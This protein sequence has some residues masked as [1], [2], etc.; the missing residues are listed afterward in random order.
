MARDMERLHATQIRR[1]GKGRHGD[2]G[3]LWLHVTDSGRYYFFRWGGSGRNYFSLGPAH[4]ISLSKAREKARACRELLLDGRDPKAEAI[5]Q[6]VI[7]KLKAQQPTFSQAADQYSQF[8]GP[9]AV[10]NCLVGNPARIFN[11]GSGRRRVARAGLHGAGPRRSAG[12][13]D[14]RRRRRP[15]PRRIEAEPGP[16]GRARG[17]E[18]RCSDAGAAWA[19]RRSDQAGRPARRAPRCRPIE[20]ISAGRTA[21]A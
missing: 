16:G 10:E 9:P 13:G 21:V 15:H 8:N 5:A 1:L 18:F 12:R 6:R 2:G 20:P 19:E 11:H 14:R 3:G 17:A 7:A 4:T